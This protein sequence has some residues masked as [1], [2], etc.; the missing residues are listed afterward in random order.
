MLQKQKIFIYRYT[1]IKIKLFCIRLK[2]NPAA[3]DV[4]TIEKWLFETAMYREVPYDQDLEPL[5]TFVTSTREFRFDGPC[6]ECGKN[7]T[8]HPIGQVVESFNVSLFVERGGSYRHAFQC[9]R[10][11]HH[12]VEVFVKLHP[13]KGTFEKVGQNPSLASLGEADLEKYRKILGNS[14]FKE[15]SKGVG[16]AAH[17]VGIGSFVY[18]RRIFETLIEEAHLKATKKTDWDEDAFSKAR[19]VEKIALL[20][21]ELPN[22]LVENKSLYGLLSKGIHHLTEQECLEIFPTLK[23]GIEL[24]LDEKIE[25]QNRSEKIKSAGADIQKINAAMKGEAKS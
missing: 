25:I 1:N 16:L 19:M 10:N 17:G 6:P 22:F 12:M 15:L 4:I 24:I 18:L 23:L 21:L 9:S 14:K 20:T 7:T 13:E 5:R 8:Y 2:P 11:P 3:M